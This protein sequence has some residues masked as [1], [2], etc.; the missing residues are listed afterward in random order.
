MEN[1]PINKSTNHALHYITKPLMFDVLTLRDPNLKEQG[2]SLGGAG[3]GPE[4]NGDEGQSPQEQPSEV[5]A[6]E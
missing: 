1:S 3:S 2:S 4:H 6:H 5:S